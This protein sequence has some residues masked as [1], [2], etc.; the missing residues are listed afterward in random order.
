MATS[1]QV[2]TRAMSATAPMSLR[3]RMG[4]GPPRSIAGQAA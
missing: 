2:T 1:A 3:R 4:T